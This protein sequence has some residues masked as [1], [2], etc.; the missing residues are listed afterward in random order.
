MPRIRR[1]RSQRADCHDDPQ[2]GVGALGL[3]IAAHLLGLITRPGRRFVAVLLDQQV[4]GAGDVEIRE[5]QAPL[6][7][8]VGAGQA[9]WRDRDAERLGGSQVKD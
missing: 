5:G 6:D 9:R 1:W 3:A 4:R 7:H 2:S 8:L